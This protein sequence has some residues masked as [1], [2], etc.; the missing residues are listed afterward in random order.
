MSFAGIAAVLLAAGRSERFGADKL[1]AELGGRPLCHHAAA[2]LAALPFARRIAVVAEA[3]HRLEALGFE[4]VRTGAGAQSMSRSIVTGVR[5]LQAAQPDGLLL[6]LADMPFVPAAQIEALVAGFDGGMV[7]SAAQ[8]RAQPPAL[9]GPGHFEALMQLQGD[10]GARDLLRSARLVE[11]RA[12]W[13]QDIDTRSDLEAAQL[14]LT[15]Q[16]RGP[17]QPR[18]A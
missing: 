8:G 1:A 4:I 7:A 10:K 3:S 13:L 11:A 14:R 5:A 9:F 6:A 12:E 15:R 16:R 17:S 18:K 2:M